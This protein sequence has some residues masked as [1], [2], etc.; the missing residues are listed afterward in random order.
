MIFHPQSAWHVQLPPAIRVIW[1]H[2]VGSLLA[3]V[4]RPC[5]KAT[6][7]IY[8]QPLGFTQQF[9]LLPLCCGPT[10]MHVWQCTIHQVPVF[11]PSSTQLPPHHLLLHQ[12]WL[13]SLPAVF[14][15]DTMKIECYK[16]NRCHKYYANI[17]FSF[18]LRFYSWAAD[19]V[20]ADTKCGA[21][22]PAA[23]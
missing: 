13:L 20:M 1:Q 11:S 19:M 16:I 3:S 15:W 18:C 2:A 7:N 6:A 14:G 9:A 12:H 5:A 10:W 21:L 8:G 22:S 4:D 17:F 23:L